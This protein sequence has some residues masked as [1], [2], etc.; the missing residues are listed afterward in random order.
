M[1]FFTCSAVSEFLLSARFCALLFFT[2]FLIGSNEF[3]FYEWVTSNNGYF[4]EFLIQIDKDHTWTLRVLWM[5][6]AFFWLTG[7]FYSKNCVFWED[8]Y[9]HDVMAFK[10]HVGKMSVSYSISSTSSSTFTFLK[11]LQPQVSKHILK[12]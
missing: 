4:N 1:W 8:N 11:S 5:E 10:L 2:C 3:W 9:P 12:W 7:C 6:E